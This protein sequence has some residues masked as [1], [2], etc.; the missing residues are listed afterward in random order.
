ML[1]GCCHLESNAVGYFRF[2]S[3]SWW[4]RST[5][6]AADQQES[7]K[8]GKQMVGTSHEIVQICKEI[9]PAMKSEADPVK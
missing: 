7:F 5:F 3:W 2:C 9:G 4:S 6:S 8:E 1:L